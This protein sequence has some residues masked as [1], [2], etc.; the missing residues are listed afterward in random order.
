MAAS[1]ILNNGYFYKANTPGDDSKTATGID[2]LLNEAKCPFKCSFA[3]YVNRKNGL[4][5][6]YHTKNDK[7]YGSSVNKN[8][9]Y[10]KYK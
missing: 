4:Y 5:K 3:I 10:Y 1:N 7:V 9:K 2:I 8:D 6:P